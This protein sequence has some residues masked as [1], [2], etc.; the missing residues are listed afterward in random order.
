MQHIVLVG[1]FS[2]SDWVYNQVSEA[3]E[4][5]GM[6]IIRPDNHVSVLT[7]LSPFQFST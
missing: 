1:G 6:H 2:A 3:L 7:I 5:F 4:P